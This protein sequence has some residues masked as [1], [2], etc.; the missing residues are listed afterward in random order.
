MIV[1]PVVAQVF[2]FLFGACFGSLLNGLD[3][4]VEGKKFPETVF[5]KMSPALRTKLFGK[6]GKD[7]AVKIMDEVIKG[8]ASEGVK[9]S[10]EF[11]IDKAKGDETAEDLGTAAAIEFANSGVKNLEAEIAKRIKKA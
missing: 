9:K 3:S 4:W 8:K 7:E 2:A 5:N 10:L 1:P 6:T 11:A